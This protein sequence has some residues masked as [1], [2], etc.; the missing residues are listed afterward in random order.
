MVT[1]DFDYS[2]DVN[3]ISEEGFEETF[4][5]DEYRGWNL[6]GDDLFAG[7]FLLT[8][9]TFGITLYVIVCIAMAKMCKEIVGFRFLLSQALTDILLLLQFGIWPG[10]VIL[11][12]YEFIPD[13]YKWHMHVYLDFTW[14]AM[15]Y[16]YSI[17]AWSRLAAVQFPNW[18]RTLSNKT[19]LIICSTAW[20]G[21]L[22][23]TLIEHQL[24]WFEILYYDP[25]H[26]ALTGNWANYNENGTATYY[27]IFNWSSI[28]LPFP[29]YGFALY[30]LFKRQRRQLYNSLKHRIRENSSISDYSVQRQLSIETRLLIPCIINTILFVVG[31]IAISICSKTT[32]KWISWTVMVIFAA[33]SFVNPVLYL[34]FSSV[35]RRHLF[36]NCEKQLNTS[37]VYRDF[38]FKSSSQASISYQQQQR[39]SLIKW[40]KDSTSISY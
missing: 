29:F 20:V 25:K 37:S 17:V 12:K 32:G 2:N 27:M 9:G 24:P 33:N 28:I 40:K 5:E 23:Q 35:I 39:T 6:S 11:T 13:D 14:W 15:V 34:C 7:L 38:D 4:E 8:F 22:L 19:C 10:V 3:L 26:Y 31:Q 1:G 30:V 36:T 21:G 18:F 16:H